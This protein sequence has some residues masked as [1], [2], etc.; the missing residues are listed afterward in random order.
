MSSIT[1][2]PV[3]VPLCAEITPPGSKSLTNRV[4]PIAA[5][6]RGVSRLYG[7]LESEDT[8]MMMNALKEMGCRLDYD[9]T[10][11]TAV[12]ESDGVGW[13]APSPLTLF[14]ANS[15]T[16]L[17]FLAG[18][19]CAGRGVF[20]LDGVPRMR[21][22]PLG[23]LISGLR[24][25]GARLECDL[26]EGFPPVTIFADGLPGG[27]ATI[28]GQVSS[29]FLS[30]LLMVSP[31]AQNPVVLKTRGKLV[32]RPYVDMTLA[33]MRAFGATVE[34]KEPSEEGISS[35]FHI[36]PR[37]TYRAADYTIEPDA[38]A[39][40]YFFASAAVA[41]GSV[42]VRNLTRD[43]LQ[44]DVRFC[45]RLEEMGCRVEYAS[46]SIL[47]ARDPNTPL[48]GIDTDMHFISDTA[49]TLA[50]VA[51]FADSPTTI[52]NVAN[53]RVKETDR[54]HAVVTELQKFGARTE[55]WEDGFRVYPLDFDAPIPSEIR[56]ET[57]NDHRMAMSFAVAGLRIPGVT[58][59]NPGC[60]SKTYPRFFEDLERLVSR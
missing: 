25:L 31:L 5:L 55:E 38:S 43:A 49:Q 18:M 16:T 28:P 7:V 57:W 10:Q 47:V 50:V 39:A 53:M 42:R 51:L 48:R 2:R 32:S 3:E 6:A 14:C 23:D 56:V 8:Q 13:G 35:E 30:A 46:D 58:I 34:E 59:L 29:Q 1:I 52:R 41:S 40:S 12:V 11:A 19:C 27:V 4:L 15:G 9:P 17:R 33:V 20:T 54:I 36:P 37:Q 21:E 45:D 22:R 24:S 60:T 44:G 26:N